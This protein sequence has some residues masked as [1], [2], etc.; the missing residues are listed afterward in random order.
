[1]A[2]LI[3]FLHVR[4]LNKLYLIVP[5]R[6]EWKDAATTGTVCVEQIMPSCTLSTHCLNGFLFALL[7]VYASVVTY[8]KMQVKAGT[9]FDEILVTDS[10]E[11]AQKF[12]EDTWASK[13]DSEKEAH[14]ALKKKQKDEEEVRLSTKK[15]IF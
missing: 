10:L 7:F 6:R 12:A 8:S 13:K 1:M 14:D 11:E 4:R 9:I 5:W 15:Q 3:V 2:S